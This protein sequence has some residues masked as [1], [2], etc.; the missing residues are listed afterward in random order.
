[1]QEILPW[2][3]RR[4]RYCSPMQELT[5]GVRPSYAPSHHERAETPPARPSVQPATRRLVLILTASPR[6]WSPRGDPQE[7][8]LVSFPTRVGFGHPS[9]AK[10]IPDE[11]T[12]EDKV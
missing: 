10:W 8:V 3:D 7:R 2:V 9:A 5:E 6:M 1:M 12:E 11:D 4:D